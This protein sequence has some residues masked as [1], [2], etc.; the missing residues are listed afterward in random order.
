[1]ILSA[2]LLRTLRLRMRRRAAMPLGNHSPNSFVSDAVMTRTTSRTVRFTRPFVLSGLGEQPAGVYE[3]ETDEAPLPGLSFPVYRR[4][5][6]RIIIPLREKWAT[7]FQSVPISA[8]ELDAALAQD[9]AN[10]ND[11]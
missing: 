10:A 2:E 6:T 11:R 9:P 3:I 5:E 1:V 7:G 8:E 4:I